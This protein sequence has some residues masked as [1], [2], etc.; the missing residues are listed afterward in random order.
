[1]LSLLIPSWLNI[2]H[3]LGV[4]TQALSLLKCFSS[5]SSHSRPLLT[6]S[7]PTELIYYII[8]TSFFH[9]PLQIHSPC[10]SPPGILLTEAELYKNINSLPCPLGSCWLQLGGSFGRRWDMGVRNEN[11]AREFTPLSPSLWSFFVLVPESWTTSH[12]W[13]L[14]TLHSSYPLRPR[15]V[16]TILFFFI[17][18]Y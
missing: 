12:L 15:V 5:L 13:F 1:M 7:R 3:S 10:E 8:V 16:I 17:Y 9:L 11:K 6:L 14:V 2:S 18:L 4:H